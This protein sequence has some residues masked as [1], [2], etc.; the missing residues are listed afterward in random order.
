MVINPH[1]LRVGIIKDFGSKWYPEEDIDYNLLSDE[2]NHK[3]FSIS[4]K[5]IQYSLLDRKI[6]LV[7]LLGKHEYK[8]IINKIKSLSRW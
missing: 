6:H 3:H 7:Q 2:V 1:S 4:G 8:R 5:L